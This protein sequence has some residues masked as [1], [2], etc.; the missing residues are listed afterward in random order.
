MKTKRYEVKTIEEAK[1]LAVAEF[2][3]SEKDIE[4]TILSEKKGFLGIGGKIEVEASIVVDGTAKGKEYLQKI[5]DANNIKGQIEKKVRPNLVEYNIDAGEMNGFL[6]G[7]NSRN[8]IALQ[9]LV[10]I[11]VNNYYDS[12][13]LM[14]VLVDVGGYKKRR[15]K[16]LEHMAVQFGKQ[17]AK[18]KQRIKLDYLNAYERKIVHN[19]LSSWKDVNTFSEGDEPKRFLVIEPKENK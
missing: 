12:E 15:E 3:V 16:T 17:V 1:D 13:E 6:I 8:L 5:L 9:T 7:K 14:T 10:T 19:K 11:V 2:G 18:S 4:F